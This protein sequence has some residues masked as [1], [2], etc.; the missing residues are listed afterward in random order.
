NPP[1]TAAQDEDGTL[2][3]AADQAASH[4]RG[5]D[6]RSRPE[7]PVTRAAVQAKR[8]TRR[9]SSA[10]RNARDRVILPTLDQLAEQPDLAAELPRPSVLTVLYRAM[11]VQQACF[12]VLVADG[13]TA[14]LEAVQR[15][16]TGADEALNV[17]AAA[18]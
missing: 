16:A 10:T 2:S 12:A 11:A 5:A 8:L 3:G 18:A 14:L 17:T 7:A 1:G 15:G 9:P 6:Y 13:H 4:G